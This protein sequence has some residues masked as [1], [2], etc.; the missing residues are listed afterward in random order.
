MYFQHNFWNNF[1]FSYVQI[2]LVFAFVSITFFYLSI[3][4]TG[5]EQI[6]L[7]SLSA[8]FVCFAFFTHILEAMYV[9]PILLF[10]TV[11]YRKK[12][13]KPILIT[14]FM[15][16]IILFLFLHIGLDGYYIFIFGEKLNLLNEMIGI[17]PSLLLAGG[18][19]ALISIKAKEKISNV[20]FYFTG[21][22][23]FLIYVLGFYFWN[24]APE[25]DGLL[26]YANQLPWYYLSTKFGI[27]GLLAI[28]SLFL[29]A[30]KEKWSRLGAVWIIILFIIGNIW[31]GARMLDYLLPVIAISAAYSII[32]LHDKFVNFKFLNKNKLRR[33]LAILPFLAIIVISS[34]S[35][36]Y[37]VS[38]YVFTPPDLEPQTVNAIRWVFN[39]VPKDSVILLPDNYE[40][41]KAFS[42]ISLH[43]TITM[44]NFTLTAIESSVEDVIKS[45]NIEYAYD[46][47]NPMIFSDNGYE[48]N[49]VEELNSPLA[50][51]VSIENKK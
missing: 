42:T 49:Y 47:D 21:G 25:Y 19:L 2:S 34:S 37:G 38:H 50:K 15:I 5:R 39:N 44:K 46:I 40:L 3:K 33:N 4:S 35:Y 36:L 10:M 41:N 30:H 11:Y 32:T 8:F 45:R 13:T 51:L 28:S 23:L 1:H 14:F 16:I 7:S 48:F 29:G 20:F 43:K 22:G 18:Y 12:I 31:W 26:Y 24:V 27:V 17:D 9:V 6:F